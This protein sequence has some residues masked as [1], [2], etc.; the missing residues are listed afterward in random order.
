MVNGK[1][2]RFGIISQGTN[3]NRTNF[4]MKE[5]NG[6]NVKRNEKKVKKIILFKLNF[7]LCLRHEMI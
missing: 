4:N 3:F 1:R 5:K 6:K 7:S 2:F